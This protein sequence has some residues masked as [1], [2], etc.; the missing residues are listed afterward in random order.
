MPKF[1]DPK[2]SRAERLKRS[3][4][5]GAGANQRLL[6]EYFDFEPALRAIEGNPTMLRALG[7]IAL[8][9]AQV[10]G[11]LLK[12]ATNFLKALILAAA[13]NADRSKY[14]RRL[15]VTIIVSLSCL[16]LLCKKKIT[17]SH[18]EKHL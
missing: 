1:R 14:G 4:V 12:G 16:V 10:S 9:S 18:T 5:K 6:T 17:V 13:R 11:G 2:Y 7:T 15:V 3:L 8:P